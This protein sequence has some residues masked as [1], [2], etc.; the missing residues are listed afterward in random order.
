MPNPND[1]IDITKPATELLIEQFNV[2]NDTNL[3]HND[4]LFS[5]PEP[6]SVPST[7][8]NTKV[9][10]TPKVSSGYYTNREFYYT[11]IDVAQLFNNDKVEITYTEDDENLSDIID[12]IN[13]KYG[14]YLQ[15][16][17]YIDVPLPDYAEL[18]TNPN[19]SIAVAINPESYI[20]VGTGNLVLGERV[21]PIDN[22]NYTRNILV[23]TDSEDSGIFGN[24]VVLLDT[25]YKKASYFKVFRNTTQVDYFRV[26]KV[27]PLSNRRFYLGGQFEFEA[28][29][30]DDP[31]QEYECS[32]VIIDTYGMITKASEEPL[33]GQTANK[34][35]GRNKN[36]DKIYLADVENLVTPAASIK[37][38]KYDIDGVLDDTFDPQLSYNPVMVRV[39]S[40][41][42]IYT[43]SPQFTGPLPN[44]P[45][46][47]GKQVRI[48]RLND[49]GSIDNSF[50]PVN[51]RVNSGADDVMPL[52]DLLPMDGGGFF[53]CFKP[54]YGTSVLSSYPIVNDVPFVSGSD[55][56]DCAFN[57]VFRINQSGGL[58]GAFKTVLPNNKPET[59]MIDD[60]DL[61]EDKFS[62]MYADNKLSVLTYRNNPIT[63]FAQF[64]VMNMSISGNINN[65]AP[66]RYVNDI[67]WENIVAMNKF[68]NGQFI[69][70]GLGRIKL[71]TGGWGNA[72]YLMASYNQS[73]QLTGIVY[74]PVVVGTPNAQIY[75]VNVVE[76][77]VEA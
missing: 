33:F 53:A 60:V 73:A 29:L 52:L 66:E 68:D 35:Y 65:I 76:W 25:E 43:V 77:L 56:D 44:D 69:L 13:T 70:S 22:Y 5:L 10:L 36:I 3:N 37:L 71:Q 49:D 12:Q 19:P 75:D 41:G 4:F 51:I 61:V 30:D 42:K 16:S 72:Q 20:Y 59:V 7:D 45:L 17:D 31:L 9:V 63:G 32:G 40:G 18:A 24:D 14:I 74:Q 64:G 27:I 6:A 11:R 62:L 54:I 57:P 67:R 39:D 8:I 46:T 2:L 26:D 58:V 34:H 15:A 23:V 21:R 50:S 28:S 38:Y 1:P 48:D 47:T 55:P